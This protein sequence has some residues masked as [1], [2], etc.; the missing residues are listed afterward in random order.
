MLTHENWNDYIAIFCYCTFW[1]WSVE[2]VA[3]KCAL[4]FYFL[5][6]KITIAILFQ[7]HYCNWRRGKAEC[8]EFHLEYGYDLQGITLSG[9]ASFVVDVSLVV[10]QFFYPHWLGVRTFSCHWF[11]KKVIIWDDILLQHHFGNFQQF[12][13]RISVCDFKN[14]V[15]S[16]ANHLWQIMWFHD[17]FYWWLLFIIIIF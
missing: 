1:I 2:F 8:H 14:I 6:Y 10:M 16:F 4:H 5:L 15:F 3:D 17:N 7:Y 12:T 9:D 13:G 11:Q